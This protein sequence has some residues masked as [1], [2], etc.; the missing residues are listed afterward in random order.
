MYVLGAGSTSSIEPPLVLSKMLPICRAA[1]A[2]RA[3]LPRALLECTPLAGAIEPL[4][5]GSWS[6][7]KGQ[8]PGTGGN[9]VPGG[10]WRGPGRSNLLPAG[11]DVAYHKGRQCFAI[12]NPSTV[13]AALG[14]NRPH[15]TT[16]GYPAVGRAAR[17]DAR[18]P[19]RRTGYGPAAV[20]RAA[21]GGHPGDD[22]TRGAAPSRQ[23]CR[24][25][26]PGGRDALPGAAVGLPPGKQPVSN[27]AAGALSRRVSAVRPCAPCPPR[28]AGGGRGDGRALPERT[29]PSPAAAGRAAVTAACGRAGCGPA[30]PPLR[31]SGAGRAAS[32]AAPARRTRSFQ[33][34]QRGRLRSASRGAPGEARLPPLPPAAVPSRPAAYRGSS[35]APLGWRPSRGGRHFYPPGSGRARARCCH[36]IAALP[37]PPSTRPPCA[38]A[39]LR[40]GPARP[41]LP[42]GGGS[43]RPAR[44]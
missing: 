36:L 16:S 6:C 5:P 18:L 22:S 33:S 31:G 15:N 44:A 11:A 25:S 41:A 27:S 24:G 38:V 20:S 34:P 29:A 37:G 12:A 10:G 42:P 40:R 14:I 26:A 28:S 4:L 21:A 1:A 19:S 17:H 9:S 35:A 43:W 23:G 32:S 39:R 8:N 3:A 7:A 30:P 2:H 13:P